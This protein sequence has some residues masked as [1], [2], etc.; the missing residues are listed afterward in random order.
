M[1][2]ESKE[3]KSCNFCGCEVPTEVDHSS[4]NEK[5]S[6]PK[7]RSPKSRKNS[8]PLSNDTNTKSPKSNS[9]HILLCPRC[10]GS[11]SNNA[12]IPSNPRRRLSSFFN[13]NNNNSTVTNGNDLQ[14]PI[15]SN[16]GNEL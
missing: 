1:G 9:N 2:G 6:C 10:H 4:Q 11:Y 15:V 16:I 13:N 12:P 5:K 3:F 14:S 7:L 8:E